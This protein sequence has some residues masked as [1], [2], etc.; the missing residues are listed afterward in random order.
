VLDVAI[1]A[2]QLAAV[3]PRVESP[4]PETINIQ[5]PFACAGG[6]GALVDYLSRDASADLRARR[7]RRAGLCGLWFGAAF[8]A[9]S[10]SAQV[11]SSS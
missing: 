1:L 4:W 11:L 9:L 8:Y 3:L 5:L 10:L 7:I 6:A 2:I